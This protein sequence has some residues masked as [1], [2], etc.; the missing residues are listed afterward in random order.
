MSKPPVPPTD[1]APVHMLRDDMAQI[2]QYT[3]PIGYRFRPFRDGDDA[4]WTALHV[5]GEPYINFT[6]E[7]FVREFGQNR[8]ALY[9][10]MVFVETEQGTPVGTITAWWTHDR[11]ADVERGMIHWVLVHPEHRRRGLTKPM[12][13]HAMARLAQEYA[14]AMLGTSTGRVW[15]LKVYLDFGFYPH[16][17]ELAAKPELI[18]AWQN[19][20]KQLQHPLLAAWL[21]E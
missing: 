21:P 3:L 4:T 19:V 1:N 14:S 7:I 17:G 20:Q 15:A 9:D 5:A 13:T 6:P 12:M 10:R 18:P 8:P 2:P 11:Y 16:P